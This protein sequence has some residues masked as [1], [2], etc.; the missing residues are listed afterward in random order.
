MIPT[1]NS[2]LPNTTTFSHPLLGSA[3]NTI[4]EQKPGLKA[5]LYLESEGSE[6]GIYVN[7]YKWLKRKTYY[8]NGG[9]DKCIINNLFANNATIKQY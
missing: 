2:S 1:P 3:Y 8:G 5:K 9:A 7:R 4:R 6:F